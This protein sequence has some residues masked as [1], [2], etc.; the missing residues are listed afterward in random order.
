MGISKGNRG[1][2]FRQTRSCRQPSHGER[3]LTDSFRPRAVE[4]V[5]SDITGGH[6]ELLKYTMC[7]GWGIRQGRIASARKRKRE[8]SRI[9]TSSR[10]AT[11][12]GVVVPVILTSWSLLVLELVSSRGF[13]SW[14]G[15]SACS[16]SWNVANCPCGAATS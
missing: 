13:G 8:C 6:F 9:S 1:Q 16:V 11:S 2:R 12:K 5:E 7:W 3:Q 10:L 4:V 15:V 14:S